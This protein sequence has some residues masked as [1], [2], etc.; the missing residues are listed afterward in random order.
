MVGVRIILD[1]IGALCVG[2]LF[3]IPFGVLFFFIVLALEVFRTAHWV[4]KGQKSVGAAVMRDR[5]IFRAE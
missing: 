4:N 5:Q 1:L 3:G 2:Y